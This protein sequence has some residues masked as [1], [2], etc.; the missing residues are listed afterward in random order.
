MKAE[1]LRKR[2]SHTGGP[3]CSAPGTSSVAPSNLPA[4]SSFEAEPSVREKPFTKKKVEFELSKPPIINSMLHTPSQSPLQRLESWTSF[5]P[6]PLRLKDY[7]NNPHSG[8][9]HQ[10]TASSSLQSN[11]YELSSLPRQATVKEPLAELP[12]LPPRKPSSSPDGGWLAWA[13][14]WGGFLV[15]FNCWGLNFSFGVLQDYY[16]RT[17]LPSTAPSRIAW[18]G[19]TQLF[20]IFVLGLPI[21]RA[22]DAGHFRIFFNVGSVL[23]VLAIFCTSFCTNY[24]QLLL[25]QGII[26]G[27]GMGMIFCSGLVVLMTY[28]KTKIGLAMGIGAAGSSVGGIVYTL[29]A[30]KVLQTSGFP[31][32]MRCIGF[33]SLATMIVPNIIFRVRLP[34]RKQARPADWS[35]L[36]DRAYMVMTLG[37]FFAFWGLYFGF[38]YVRFFYS[39]ALPLSAQLCH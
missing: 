32:T 5:E 27:L 34:P 8:D 12:S 6:V 30:Q 33:V 9:K 20:L 15:I 17:F 37:M 19:S 14:A 10:G 23:L 28:F 11:T 16:V 31:W 1:A 29:I 26:T 4:E 22:V 38:Y 18:I 24:W 3:S 13:H 36:R 2:G 35:M 7:S 39:I 25:V 21:G